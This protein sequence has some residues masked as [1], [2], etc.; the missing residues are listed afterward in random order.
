[1]TR[2]PQEIVNYIIG[3]AMSLQPKPLL[4]D[5]V[6]YVKSEKELY[7][8]SVISPNIHDVIES[9]ET[10]YQKD[11]FDCVARRHFIFQ[12]EEHIYNCDKFVRIFES[13][14][15][16]NYCRSTHFILGLLTPHERNFVLK[17]V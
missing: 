10:V 5:I 7:H 13:C 1:M 6:N 8:T 3:F 4:E 11:M 2:L 17:I 9:L 15:R 12:K 16:M 14:S